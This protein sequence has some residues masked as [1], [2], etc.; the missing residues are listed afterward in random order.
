MIPL[1][2]Q[3]GYIELVMVHVT[4][5]DTISFATD[6]SALQL[7]LYRFEETHS[8]SDCFTKGQKPL[9]QVFLTSLGMMRCMFVE[10]TSSFTNHSRTPPVTKGR[11]PGLEVFIL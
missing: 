9:V 1:I 3:D 8:T 2:H 7:L 11:V 4:I 5:A 10:E 6:V